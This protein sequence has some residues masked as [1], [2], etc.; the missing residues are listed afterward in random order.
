MGAMGIVGKG[1]AIQVIF[2]AEADRF[3]VE[4]KELQ[5]NRK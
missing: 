3:K 4:L 1:K 5:K 2:G